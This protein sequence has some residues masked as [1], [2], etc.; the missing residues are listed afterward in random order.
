MPAL[1]YAIGF[2]KS[3]ARAVGLDAD[4]IAAQF[5]SETT[6]PAV[7]PTPLTLEPLDERRMPA[8]MLVLASIGAVIFVIAALS[9]WGAGMFDKPPPAEIVASDALPVAPA[10][11]DAAA[12][13]QDAETG[14]APAEVTAPPAEGVAA[15]PVP[16]AAGAA[17]LPPGAAGVLSC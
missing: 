16:V 4:T 2:V 1:P 7:W 11:V 5:R 3:F 13:P 12:V 17:A 15:L 9:A 14:V 8:R 6:N 10:T